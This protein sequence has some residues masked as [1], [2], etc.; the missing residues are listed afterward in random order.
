MWMGFNEVL[1]VNY[2]YIKLGE[3]A[4]IFLVGMQTNSD[5]ISCLSIYAYFVFENWH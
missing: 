2:T 3:W 4:G 1:I 5:I